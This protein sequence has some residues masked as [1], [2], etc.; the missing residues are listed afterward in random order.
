M[1]EQLS[2]EY[3][4]GIF[5]QLFPLR[6][7]TQ[8]DPSIITN[9]YIADYIQF[10][11]YSKVNE[12][13]IDEINLKETIMLQALQMLL[14]DLEAN[15]AILDSQYQTSGEINTLYNSIL[16]NHSAIKNLVYANADYSLDIL[17]SMYASHSGTT[18]FEQVLQ[19]L[20]SNASNSTALI[21]AFVTEPRFI[22]LLT[23]ILNDANV[24]AAMKVTMM[25]TLVNN[26][27]YLASL[28]NYYPTET[29]L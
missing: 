9:Q 27:T 13:L 4:G 24:T 25:N 1:T 28:A 14:I 18:D 5:N 8:T 12:H 29:G 3:N 17:E 19:T 23:N 6:D 15:I 2:R 11:P 21:N 22:T 10:V 26:S 7:T 16:S 20:L